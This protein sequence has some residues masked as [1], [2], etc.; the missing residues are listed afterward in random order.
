MEALIRVAIIRYSK[1]YDGNTV[2]AVNY[3]FHKKVAHLYFHGIYDPHFREHLENYRVKNVYKRYDHILEDVFYL[4]GIPLGEYDDA[5]DMIGFSKLI[6]QAKLVDAL[7]TRIE[8]KKAFVQSQMN[9]ISPDA[10]I[11]DDEIED[12][13]T[14]EESNEMVANKGQLRAE[15]ENLGFRKMDYGEFKE[16]LGRCAVYKWDDQSKYN[17]KTLD[18]KIEQILINLVKLDPLDLQARRRK[19]SKLGVSEDK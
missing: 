5:M 7:L 6:F 19:N 9:P 18:W 17:D 4:V 13:D 16:A 1:E 12:V 3:L 10:W 15:A 14:D 8:V 11:D 2:E